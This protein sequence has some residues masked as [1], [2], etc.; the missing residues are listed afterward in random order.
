MVDAITPIAATAVSSPTRIDTSTSIDSISEHA[1][2]AARQSQITADQDGLAKDNAVD[3]EHHRHDPPDTADPPIGDR[4][5]PLSPRQQRDE[6]LEELDAAEQP[7][8][9]PRLSGESERIGTQNFDEDTPFGERVAF[10]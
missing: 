7:P 9:Q 4:D 5:E 1:W 8:G 10:V 6:V 3:R 2:T